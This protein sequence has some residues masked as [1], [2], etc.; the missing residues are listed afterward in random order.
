MMEMTCPS[1]SERELKSMQ[2]GGGSLIAEKSRALSMMLKNLQGEGGETV[3]PA[4]STV[5]VSTLPF[6]KTAN[7]IAKST[8]A[9]SRVVWKSPTSVS[10]LDDVNHFPYPVS[11]VT[12]KSNTT[13]SSMSCSDLSSL[14]GGLG[15]STKRKK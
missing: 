7:H 3:L 13:T 10:N 9:A 2:S 8:P 14:T 15:N 1:K 11:I 4:P 5:S 6:A 12:S